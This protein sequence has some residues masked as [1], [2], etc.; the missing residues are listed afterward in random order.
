M[1]ASYPTK[2][3]LAMK[4]GNKCA[5]KDCRAFLTSEGDK[6]DPVVIGEAAHVYGENQGTDKK[7]PS[8]RYKA[9][10][11]NDTRNHYDNLIY[12]CPTCHTKIDKQEKDY[13]AELLFKIKNDHE[14]WIFEQLDESMS[15]V[16]F[17]ELEIAAK[18]I[19][20]G[21]YTGNG[22]FSVIT[23]EEKIEKNGLTKEIHAL[24]TTGLS[25]SAEVGEYLVRAT[26]LDEKFTERLKT[27]FKEKYMELKIIMSGDDLFMAM[28]KFSQA[29]QRDFKQQAASLAIL[30]H[31]FHLCEVFEK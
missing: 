27:G 26:Y 24:I 19:A 18:T 12:L 21:K 13:P 3:Y 16:T 28:F 30:S 5:L 8:A 9:D 29:G 23:P 17:A 25:R 2:L 22:D 14:A 1:S 7:P 31:L 6:A 4:S 20:S 15:D 11:T 10:M